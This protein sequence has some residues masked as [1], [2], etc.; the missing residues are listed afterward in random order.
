MPTERPKERK[1]LNARWDLLPE[2]GLRLMAEVMYDGEFLYP[3]SA[4]RGY[5]VTDSD[6]APLNHAIAHVVRAASMNP[7][8]HERA[9]QMAKAAVNLVMSIALEEELP[10]TTSIE[11]S[12]HA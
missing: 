12:G 4:W 5:P 11:E 9:R 7:G 8:S 1:P 10:D 6:Q 3:G 2:P